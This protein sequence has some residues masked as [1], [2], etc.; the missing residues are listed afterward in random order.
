[1]QLNGL[2]E[3]LTGG[4][5]L[6]SQSI[7]VNRRANSSFGPRTQIDRTPDN[8]RGGRDMPLNWGMPIYF[9]PDGTSSS[10][11]LVL[12][13]DRQQLIRVHLRGITG[14]SQVGELER[15]DA[16]RSGRTR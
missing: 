5:Q 15:A 1:M 2:D 10:A 3:N 12:W 9:Y 16:P 6:G 4:S 7:G 11:Q 8:Q 14:T 13:N